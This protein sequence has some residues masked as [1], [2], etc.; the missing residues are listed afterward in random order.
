M[1]INVDIVNTE[2]YHV[3]S[4]F[5]LA[6]VD[7]LVVAFERTADNIITILNE[8]IPRRWRMVCPFNIGRS[9]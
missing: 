9:G 7:P 3:P 4:F 5:F 6:S 2:L 8:M 1:D